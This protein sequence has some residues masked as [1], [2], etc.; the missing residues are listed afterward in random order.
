M[1]IREAHPAEYEATGELL[2]E[3]YCGVDGLPLTDEYIA[4]LRDV[5]RRAASSRVFVALVD[6]ILAGTVTFVPGAG[7][8]AAEFDDPRGCGIRMLAVAPAARGLGLGKALTVACLDAAR[9]LSRRTVYL[10]TTDWMPAARRIYESM[11]FVRDETLDWV[12]DDEPDIL[13]RGYRLE[14]ARNRG[15]GGDE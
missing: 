2:V 12:P 14:L 8:S 9:R 1:E 10:H 3:A 5:A 13:L 6:G 4:E 7:S 15:R 11:G